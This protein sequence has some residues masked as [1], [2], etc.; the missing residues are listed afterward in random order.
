MRMV[1][2]AND[3]PLVTRPPET[4]AEAP[5]PTPRLPWPG[6]WEAVLW[7]FVFVAGQICGAILAVVV[8]FAA[9][10]F[11]AP[12]P[13]QFLDEQLNGFTKALDPNAQGERPQ[14]PSA[15][16]QAIAWGMLAA[17]FT[18]L[19]LI[20]L[21]LPRS[22][23]RPRLEAADRRS[24]PLRV[25]RPARAAD[26]AGVPHH[27]RCGSGTVPLRDRDSAAARDEAAQRRV[28]RVPLAPDRARGRP[29]AGGGG[30]VLV[31]RVPRPRAERPLRACA[32]RAAHVRAVRGHARRSV[33]T[34]RH[35]RDGRVSAL[36]LHRDTVHLDVDPAA[37][38]EQRHLDPARSH[39]PARNNSTRTSRFRWSS[40]W[41]HS[42]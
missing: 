5:A 26:R 13:G 32:R 39:A 11:A 37:R 17:Q 8:V 41:S 18:S 21:V 12:N 36:R 25:A 38:D 30:G 22:A 23:H 1:D 27:L 9:Y 24:A 33:A 42:R 7:C 10:A 40:R 34:V 14:V 20:A 2:P 15:F 6:I 29:R 31:P 35:H 3:P 19:A 28:P 4:V 16:G